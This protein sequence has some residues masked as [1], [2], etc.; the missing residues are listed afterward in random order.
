MRNQVKGIDRDRRAGK[1][2]LTG[3]QRGCDRLENI[4]GWVPDIS[5]L[6][7]FKG[8]HQSPHGL[9]SS[10]HGERVEGEN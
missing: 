1:C 8:R 10:P 4:T 2:N 9:E 6:V 7:K 3:A 5:C